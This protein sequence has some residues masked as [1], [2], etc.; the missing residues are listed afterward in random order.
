M[1]A[2]GD[3]PNLLLLMIRFSHSSSHSDVSVTASHL[4][5]ISL[6]LSGNIFLAICSYINPHQ[7]PLYAV[8]NVLHTASSGNLQ[9]PN[10]AKVC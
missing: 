6:F 1:G 7:E 8:E 3:T 10:A 2:M 4:G 5:P 9:V